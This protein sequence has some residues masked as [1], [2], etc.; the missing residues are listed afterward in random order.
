MKLNSR[1]YQANTNYFIYARDIA[2][3]WSKFLLDTKGPTSDY[4]N[5]TSTKVSDGTY[6]YTFTGLKFTD[7]TQTATYGTSDIADVS[8]KAN[9]T[10]YIQSS[11]KIAEVRYNKTGLNPWQGT[12]IPV[13]PLTA[14]QGRVHSVMY[15]FP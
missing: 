13:Q 1:T 12:L 7:P 2:G 10:Q 4:T 9:A 6:S 3:N 15:L 5:I 11:K 8:Y 14:V